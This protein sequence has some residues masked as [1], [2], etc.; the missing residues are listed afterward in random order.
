MPKPQVK[1]RNLSFLVNVP[2][3]VPIFSWKSKTKVYCNFF[4]V[5]RVMESI[6]ND[7]IFRPNLIV[8]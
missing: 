2:Q 1:L 5:G 3:N 6:I 8:Q 4:H 7:I